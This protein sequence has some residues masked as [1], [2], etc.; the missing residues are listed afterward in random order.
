[1]TDWKNYDWQAAAEAKRTGHGVGDHIKP[2]GDYDASCEAKPQFRKG[3]DPHAV[4]DG[5]FPIRPV[6]G[7]GSVQNLTEFRRRLA[8]WRER[9]ESPNLV[10]PIT[11]WRAVYKYES[12]VKQLEGDPDAIPEQAG[13]EYRTW[14]QHLRD[15]APND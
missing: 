6:N 5:F 2:W 4:K 8:E 1:M 9:A 12:F 10:H 3:G 15:T 14:I 11:V 7:N 13:S